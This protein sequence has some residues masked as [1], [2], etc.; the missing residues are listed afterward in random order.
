VQV[1]DGEGASNAAETTIT[2]QVVKAS[3]SR[4]TVTKDSASESADVQLIKDR[5]ITMGGMESISL[6]HQVDVQLIINR[7]PR[8][9]DICE[10]VSLAEDA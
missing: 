2:H 6:D 9:R 7:P 1:H 5:F 3:R 4:K 8:L 10:A